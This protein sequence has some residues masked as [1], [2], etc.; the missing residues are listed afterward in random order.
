MAVQPTRPPA[1]R[2][3]SLFDVDPELGETLSP[4]QLA[5][6]RH[7]AVVAV[8]EPPPGIW[9]PDGLPTE[10]HAFALL[11]LDGLVMRE[12]LLAGST[13]TEL[14]GPGD[15]VDFEVDTDALVP[16]TVHWTVPDAAMIALLDDRVLGVIRA[17]PPVARA[18]FQRMARRNARLATHRAIA[19]L[20]RVDQRLVAFFG[21]VAERW[22]RV[23]PAGLIVPLHLTHETL[24]R[25]IG[26]RRPTVSLALKELSTAGMVERRG[27]GAW[28]VRD[29][30]FTLLSPAD[31]TLAGWQP[32]EARTVA[33]PEERPVPASASTA[34]VRAEDLAALHERIEILRREHAAR[35]ARCITTLE[36]SRATRAAL[37]DLPLRR[38]AGIANG[39]DRRFRPAR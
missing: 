17:W 20:P 39:G 29:S 19:Q 15:V 8:F 38:S 24:G 2:A 1:L 28:L 3:A 5:S 33:L 36:R 31:A 32:A 34:H 14:L 11:V 7:R 21:H 13:A 25:L 22:G 23:S 10:S 30:A 12:Q 16:S 27:D 37:H 4:D 35:I 18:L 6:A 26:A 9:S